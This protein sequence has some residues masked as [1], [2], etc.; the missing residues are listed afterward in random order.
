MKCS[1]D[2]TGGTSHSSNSESIIE[3]PQGYRADD[4]TSHLLDDTSVFYNNTCSSDDYETI[5]YEYC[6]KIEDML[7]DYESFSIDLYYE[8]EED[9]NINH[10]I[11]KLRRAINKMDKIK[12]Y[13]GSL[14]TNGLKV[15]ETLSVRYFTSFDKTDI[16]TN[17][18]GEHYHFEFEKMDFSN[19]NFLKYLLH[20]YTSTTVSCSKHLE[21]EKH[22]YEVFSEE[23]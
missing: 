10:R 12:E 16:T 15:F 9:F 11:S 22:F 7:D 1:E 2:A 13:A 4:G 8:F 6:D 20:M 14:G 3:K 5:Y 17:I 18:S 23:R 19:Y 21:Q